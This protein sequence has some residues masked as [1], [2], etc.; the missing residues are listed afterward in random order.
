MFLSEWSYEVPEPMLNQRQIVDITDDATGEI[1]SLA[2]MHTPTYV[3]EIGHNSK[4]RKNVLILDK[5][6]RSVYYYVYIDEKNA[7]KK[8]DKVELLVDYGDAYEWV[9]ERKGY[10]LANMTEHLGGDEEDGAR[11][12]RNFYERDDVEK[13]IA[14]LKGN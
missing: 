13:D 1:H 2:K 7:M 10:G 5:N 4:L 3:N 8:G 9:R 14:T 12:R 11:L 6:D